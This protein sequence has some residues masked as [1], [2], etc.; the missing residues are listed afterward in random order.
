MAGKVPAS[1]VAGGRLL[2][3][4]RYS[5]SLRMSSAL[6]QSF[7]PFL[8]NS[9]QPLLRGESMRHGTAKTWRPYSVAK[10]AVIKAPLVRLASTTTVPRVMPATI[11]LR[12]GKDCLSGGRL[13][14]NCVTTAPFAAMRSKSSAFSG[15]VTMLMFT[16][17]AL[18][19]GFGVESAA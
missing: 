15:G 7:A 1:A 14:G 10:L 16:P 17:V 6:S 4:N 3:G 8:I 13:K 11:R 5:N 19:I 12:I 9:W 18:T 2:A